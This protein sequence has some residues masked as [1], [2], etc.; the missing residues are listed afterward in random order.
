MK[1]TDN[2]GLTLYEKED[3]FNI[4]AEEDS[5]NSNMKI[6]DKI[7]KEKA[8]IND[9]TNYIKEHK[10]ELKGEKGDTGEKGNT[11]A[12]GSKGADGYTPVKGTDYWT[13]SDK[14]EIIDEVADSLGI[15][16]TPSYVK[17]EAERCA[18]VVQ[19]HQNES[20]ITLMLG[21]DVHARLDHSY[22][23]QMLSSTLHASQAMKLIREKLHIDCVGILGDTLWDNGETQE[24]AIEMFGIV[25]QYFLLFQY[26]Y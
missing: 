21:S 25:H 4:T 16:G 12:T 9:M 1:P 11:G 10:E 3:K 26:F 14:N 6:I 17:E 15:E 24:Q 7:L 8:N 22:T 2:Y 20:T 23:A 13:A 19:G 5:L 18:R